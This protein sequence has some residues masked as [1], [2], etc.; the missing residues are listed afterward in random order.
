MFR[1]SIQS[2]VKNFLLPQ[3]IICKT[4]LDYSA[5]L[6]SYPFLCLP[7][8]QQLPWYYAN[9]TF[10]TPQYL[11]QCYSTFFY[12]DHIRKWIMQL[13][14]SKQ[15]HITPILSHAMY[16]TIPETNLM[17][18]NHITPIP[19][20]SKRL[21]Q[22]GFNQSLELLYTSPWH[23]QPISNILYRQRYTQMQSQLLKKDRI[24]NMKE[25]FKLKNIDISNQSILIVDD[26]MTS[27]ETLNEAAKT[28]KAKGAKFVCSLTL[29]RR[30]F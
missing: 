29:A 22:R 14:F 18:F 26:V 9:R 27:G 28:L 2:I 10:I 8:Y 1:K 12:K 7:C 24:Q 25:A 23:K 20:H 13:K 15:E 16:Y 6:L 17:M 19:L 3:C 5:K 11:D 4:N 21:M 30:V